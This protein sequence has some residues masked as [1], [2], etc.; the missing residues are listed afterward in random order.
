MRRSRYLLAVAALFVVAILW[1]GFVHV[2]LLR[3]VDASVQH[4]FRADLKEKMWLSVVQTAAIVA[5]FVYGY[6]R[7]RR[8]DGSIE[9][10]KYGLFFGILTGLL[11]DLNQYVLYPIPLS[12]AAIWFAFGLAEF[13]LYGVVASRI[14]R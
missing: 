3:G 9:G 14:L 12:V 7:F 8:G 2:V 10:L 6:V 13:T 11:V 4:L 5:V 1:N